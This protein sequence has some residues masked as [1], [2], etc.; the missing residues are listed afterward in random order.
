MTSWLVVP[1]ISEEICPW[2]GSGVCHNDSTFPTCSSFVVHVH[3]FSEIAPYAAVVTVAITPFVCP[4]MSCGSN[5]QQTA[6]MSHFN[7]WLVQEVTL[8]EFRRPRQLL[9]AEPAH[10]HTSCPLDCSRVRR[11][12]RSKGG[13]TTSQPTTS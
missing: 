7:E 11:G 6:C 1:T 2:Q 8:P 5:L 4:Q 13:R 3:P 10:V 12:S 9:F